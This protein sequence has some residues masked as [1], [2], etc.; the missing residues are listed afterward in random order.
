[1]T[2]ESVQVCVKSGITIVH[3]DCVLCSTYHVTVM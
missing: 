3:E 2:N 1:M